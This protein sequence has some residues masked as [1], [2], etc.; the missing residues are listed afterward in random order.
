MK[1]KFM[2]MVACAAMLLAT[3]CKDEKNQAESIIG[4]VSKPT[5]VAPESYD[6]SSSMTAIVAIDLTSV[7]TAEQLAAVNYQRS[8]DDLL[9]AFAGETCLGVGKWLDEASAYW[10]FIAAPENAS[11]ITIKHY[12]ASLKHVFVSESIPYS[13][14]ANLGT[15]DVPYRPKWTVAQ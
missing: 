4:N 9:A 7:Y 12:S 5:W 11:A 2:M 14:G 1:T 15:V 13:N 10:L 6:M 3:G 8:S